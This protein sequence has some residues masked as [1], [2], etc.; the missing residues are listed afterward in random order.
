M[1]KYSYIVVADSKVRVFT[2]S[3]DSAVDKKIVS[4]FHDYSYR[5]TTPETLKQRL[6][7]LRKNKLVFR[8]KPIKNTKTF[9]VVKHVVNE[10]TSVSQ[11]EW[12]GMDRK[13]ALRCVEAF[14][15]FFPEMLGDGIVQIYHSIYKPIYKAPKMKLDAEG[16]EVPVEEKKKT[17]KAKVPFNYALDELGKPQ[18][19]HVF[20]GSPIKDS[21]KEAPVEEPKKD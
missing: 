20:K 18:R 17:K 5:T 9:V 11:L 15:Q 10:H 1:K 16:N 14:K 4:Y 19:P 21:D 8:F 6:A 2:A 3:T 7:E 12:V 13:C